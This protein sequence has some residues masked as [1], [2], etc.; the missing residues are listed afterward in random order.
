MCSK[1]Y[2]K[3]PWKIPSIVN[4]FFRYFCNASWVFFLNK[5]NP[6]EILGYFSNQHNGSRSSHPK[7]LILIPTEKQ[8]TKS[9][10]KVSSQTLSYCVPKLNIIVISFFQPLSNLLF[11]WSCLL[12][13][14]MSLSNKTS[15]SV[16][17]TKLMVTLQFLSFIICIWPPPW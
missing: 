8:I 11:F 9:H 10:K 4:F 5:N 7:F 16:Q 1:I 13:V 17:N 15:R 6:L 3:S 2:G 14:M 12:K